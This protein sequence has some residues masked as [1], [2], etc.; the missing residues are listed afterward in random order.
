VLGV[1]LDELG[2]IS[3]DSKSPIG[4]TK[5]CTVLAQF[6]VMCLLNDG[7]DRSD[8][9]AGIGRAM[10]ERISKMAKRVGVRKE[11]TIT[12]G[13]AKNSAVVSSLKDVLGVEI[14]ELNGLDPQIVGALGAALFAR[15]RL[16]R[17]RRR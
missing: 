13:V 15:E 2:P 16:E 8:I 11:V 10:A 7:K 14:L 1:S 4:I 6:D 17:E 9:A 5:T 3:F 12:G